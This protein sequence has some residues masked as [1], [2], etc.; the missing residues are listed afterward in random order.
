MK[1][2]W[3]L[4]LCL[5]FLLGAAGQAEAY[6]IH[7]G[8]LVKN[9]LS[10][11]YTYRDIPGNWS[12]QTPAGSI[13]YQ[14]GQIR[15]IK[16]K[17]QEFFYG[18][19]AWGKMPDAYGDELK[20]YFYG[21]TTEEEWKNLI[22]FN[23]AFLNPHSQ[24]RAEIDRQLRLLAVESAGSLAEEDLSIRMDNLEPF[25]R[26]SSD[27]PEIYTLGGVIL[28]QSGNLTFPMYGRLYFF[29]NED[30]VEMVFF[31]VPDEGRNY[32]EYAVNDLVRA[33]ARSAA[34][35]AYGTDLSVTLARY[36]EGQEAQNEP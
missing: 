11:R 31:L 2:K 15:V 13:P 23:R 14:L 9:E 25:R 30:H 10:Y 24:V 18:Y 34:V 7:M 19:L 32:L 5:A 16:N 27:D 4:V 12:V 20:P 35:S 36:K 3:I 17:T 6:E 1:C 29:P 8:D 22:A 28:F 21:T 26:L 33:M